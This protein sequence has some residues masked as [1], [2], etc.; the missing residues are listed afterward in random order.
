MSPIIGR[1]LYQAL[2]K[3]GIAD[4][5]TRRVTI[6]IPVNDVVTVYVERYG[7]SRMLEI[8]PA[9]AEDPSLSIEYSEVPP[10]A[11]VSTFGQ[12]PGTETIETVSGL[13]KEDTE[14]H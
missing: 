2:V 11:D 6:D 10:I 12:K 1:R 7:D 14:N 8:I 4:D 5:L 9:I 3:A 13:T